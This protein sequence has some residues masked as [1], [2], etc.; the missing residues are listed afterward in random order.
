MF[1]YLLSHNIGSNIY[2]GYYLEEVP[3]LWYDYFT[4]E[5]GYIYNGGD[6]TIPGLFST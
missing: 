2:L 4:K 1:V 5:L 3:V 6:H